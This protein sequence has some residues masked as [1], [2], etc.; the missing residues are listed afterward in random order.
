[1]QMP[2]PG[3]EHR[4]LIDALAGDWT[5]EETLF[6]SAWMPIQEQRQGRTRNRAALGG[7][8][9]INDYEQLR[10]GRVD[11]YGHGVYGWDPDRQ[12]YTMD[13]F[14]SM[15]FTGGET[16]LGDWHGERSSPT[17]RFENPGKSRYE[18]QLLDANSYAFRIFIGLGGEYKPMMEAIFRRVAT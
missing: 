5:S 9:L 13:W 3:P 18:Y 17:L 16:V 15:S 7:L 4:R 8:F 11:F 2:V 14:D 1:M 10:D 6:A 12:R